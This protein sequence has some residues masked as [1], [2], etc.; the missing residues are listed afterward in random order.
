MDGPLVIVKKQL[1]RF[2]SAGIKSNASFWKV[3]Y[4]AT[5]S[6]IIRYPQSMAARPMMSMNQCESFLGFVG[7][8]DFKIFNPFY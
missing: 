6:Y 2:R 7:G 5:A 3:S 8:F 4:F 1:C